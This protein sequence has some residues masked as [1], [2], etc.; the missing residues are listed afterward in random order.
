M[1]P[2][3][4]LL[5]RTPVVWAVSLLSLAVV[6]PAARADPFHAQ[7]LPLGQRA[8]GMGGAYTAIA[9][10]P[11]ATFYNPAGIIM[12]SD[13]ALSASMTLVAFDRATVEGGYRTEN[14]RSRLSHST[15]TSLPTF[16]SAVKQLGKR[17]ALGR[18][19]HAFALST[20]TR[21]QR[22]M[23]FDVQV[24]QPAVDGSRLATLSVDDAH[25]TVWH[26]LS[27]AY[28]PL[29]N[30]AIG[31]SGFLSITRTNYTEE[32][33]AAELGAA[34]QMQ[35]S[36][37]SPRNSWT[38]HLASTNVKNML[39]RVGILYRASE[40]LR[41]GFMVQPPSLHVRGRAKIR[42]RTL[43]TDLTTD[44][45]G[46]S[47][48]NVSEDNLVSRAP[49]PWELRAGAAYA[50]YHW[51]MLSGD[52]SFY[53]PSGS[54]RHPIV[55]IGPRR[56]DPETGVVPDAGAF[57]SETWRRTANANV[58]L[59]LEA[60]LKDT[61]AIRSGIYTD[62]SSAPDVPRRSNEYQPP[63]VHR[64]GGTLSFGLVSDGYDISL[65]MIGL[66]G[67]GQA[68][69]FD[70]QAT[71]DE[72]YQRTVAKDRMFLFFLTGV[73]SA[74]RALTRKAEETLRE[75]R[76]PDPPVEP[77]PASEPDR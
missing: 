67:R 68:L 7:T 2:L 33:I 54:Q 42:M 57:V 23:S 74:V 56:E 51:L 49:Q 48:L 60:I 69:S 53:G 64:V 39:V 6:A 50:L 55:A 76:N 30:L 1:T 29:P 45:A 47:L 24:R 61:I 9:D 43:R 27:Y 38:S 21:S 58:A 35:G 26:G 31:L 70:A 52:V 10:D 25:R 44:P 72:A 11:S 20:F 15:G 3:R 37:T 40:R 18:R 41:L 63:C 34:D 32:R 36:V 59:G 17:D 4:S 73:K 66:L 62:F 13:S 22:R 75:L 12:S 28:R 19:Q 77:E 46:S 5:P 65:G 71:A 16:V 14:G 8:V